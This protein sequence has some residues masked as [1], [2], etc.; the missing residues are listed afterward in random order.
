[1]NII[2]RKIKLINTKLMKFIQIIATFLAIFVA[3]ASAK[4][5]RRHH[6]RTRDACGGT[7]CAGNS[8]CC[9]NDADKSKRCF[10]LHAPVTKTTKCN[11]TGY[12]R[13][14]FD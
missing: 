12:T 11:A 10:G 14:S 1:M 9:K 6:S 13:V 7:P 8:I 5:H 4:K 2:T 3:L